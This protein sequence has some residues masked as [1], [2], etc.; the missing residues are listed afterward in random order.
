MKRGAS[1]KNPRKMKLKSTVELEKVKQKTPKKENK[2]IKEYNSTKKKQKREVKT[3]E[4]TIKFRYPE[5]TNFILSPKRPKDIINKL[6]MKKIDK[7]KFIER[8][9]FVKSKLYEEH[10]YPYITPNYH[11]KEDETP[12]LFYDYYKI[13][14]IIRNKKCQLVSRYHEYVLFLNKGEYLI[15]YSPRKD[16]YVIMKYLLFFVYGYDRTSYCKKCQKY[17]DLNEVEFSYKNLISINENKDGENDINRKLSLI[18]SSS[19]KSFSKKNKNYLVSK[20]NS[21]INI[22]NYPLSS[23]S[24]SLNKI[25]KL[26]KRHS[27]NFG[28]VNSN[29]RLLN[30]LNTKSNNNINHSKEFNSKIERKSEYF[31]GLGNPQ[32]KNIISSKMKKPEYLFI[33]DIPFKLVPNCLPNFY[34]I[35]IFIYNIFDN[36]RTNIRKLKLNLY[37]D[38]KEK[39]IKKRKWWEEKE[40]ERQYNEFF[41]KISFSSEDFYIKEKGKEILKKDVYHNPNR[42]IKNDNDIADIENL[43]SLFDD[44]QNISKSDEINSD[45]K[46]KNDSSN[47][48]ENEYRDIKHQL[49]HNPKNKPLN[50][51]SNNKLKSLLSIKSNN[52]QSS[53]SSSFIKTNENEDINKDSLKNFNN[54]KLKTDSSNSIIKSF[55]DNIRKYS[56][57]KIVESNKENNS[58]KNFGDNNPLNSKINNNQKNTILNSNMER[59]KQAINNKN[60]NIFKNS[61][62]LNKNHNKRYMLSI[63]KQINKEIKSN[64]KDN[65]IKNK[66]LEFIPYIT[67]KN[68]QS[69]KNRLLNST[70]PISITIDT[71]NKSSYNS[72]I[73]NHSK[74]YI[75][76]STYEFAFGKYKEKNQ[77]KYKI[78]LIKDITKEFQKTTFLSK[79][80]SKNQNKDFFPS[81]DF[82]ISCRMKSRRHSEDKKN[83]D[84]NYKS[85]Y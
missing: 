14:K 52:F 24:S 84:I 20:F 2:K 6:I 28:I 12:P 40:D 74:K 60:I 77:I 38:K 37:P 21:T 64:N 50:T 59:Y 15:R 51:I 72:E 70:K 85:G 82:L 32:N 4:L 11:L 13:N 16:Y 19:K 42:R 54:I 23:N 44:I 62:S 27:V 22:K 10:G 69:S 41:K 71:P 9:K 63:D 65:L 45:Y 17:Y 39:K 26:N 66:D 73:K 31:I 49:N 58:I 33:S 61:M 48:N 5:K 67:E 68:N 55:G 75:F 29:N 83:A 47:L 30:L 56:I 3:K 36:Y 25:L 8:I 43:I 76:K 81:I 80:K 57:N 7:N 79:H 18:K 53:L 1:L 35:K 46:D 78:N 34:P